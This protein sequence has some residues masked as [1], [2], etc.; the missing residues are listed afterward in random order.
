MISVEGMFMFL[1]EIF[2][3]RNATTIRAARTSAVNVS[4]EKIVIPSF[5][6]R[7]FVIMFLISA[8]R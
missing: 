5:I 8:L 3:A 4:K 6:R 1:R 2:S 7:G